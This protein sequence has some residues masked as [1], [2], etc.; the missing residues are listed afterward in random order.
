MKTT[1]EKTLLAAIAIVMLL[2]VL[3]PLWLLIASSLKSDENQ[4]MLDFG[5]LR[6]FWVAL[7]GISLA[8]YRE[9]IGDPHAPVLLFLRN[10]FAVITGIVFF[11]VFVNS[12]CAYAL[13]RLKFRGRGAILAVTVSLIIIP[14]EALAVPLL[15]LVNR[16]DLLDTLTVQIIP[17]IAH[18]FSI[19]LFYQFF[20]K[21]PRELDEA[22]LVEGASPLQIYWK[23]IMPLSLPTVSTVA[24]LQS[25]EYWNSYLWPLMATRDTGVR[26]VAL[27]L[28]SFFS[29]PPPIWGN[30]MAFSVIISLPILVI[31]LAFQRWFIQS[32]VGSA[33]KG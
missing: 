18:P 23:V 6:A 25:L 5:S 33:V 29:T 7:S 32:V 27:A 12:L 21:L 28:A 15:L 26:P 31:Y 3:G 9:V 30:L 19:Y 1:T 13:A 24:I 20:A 4:I 2:A 16:L 8:N 22:A 10:S 17:F 11:G 14:A